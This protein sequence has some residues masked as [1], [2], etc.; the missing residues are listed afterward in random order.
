M[1][2]LV[3]VQFEHWHVENKAQMLNKGAYLDVPRALI[4]RRYSRRTPGSRTIKQPWVR[5]ISFTWPQRLCISCYL[6]LKLRHYHSQDIA[7]LLNG[8]NSRSMSCHRTLRSCRKQVLGVFVF[9]GAI[10]V[11]F[12]VGFCRCLRLRASRN[13]VCLE[14]STFRNLLVFARK[15]TVL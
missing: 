13:N 11:D 15:K 5:G 4:P 1:T 8:D 7:K 3:T 10:N 2:W 12:L 14:G 9:P 6:G